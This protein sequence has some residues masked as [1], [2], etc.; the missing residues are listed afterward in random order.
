MLGI[1]EHVPGCGLTLVHAEV[2]VGVDETAGETTEEDTNLKLGHL[3]VSL[4]DA[5]VVAVAIEE[6]QAILL[7][8]GNTSLVEEAVVQSDIFAFGLRGNFDYLKG[9][10]G[11]VVGLGEGHDIGN[12]HS[13]TG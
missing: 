12:E 13:G 7:A 4:D 3:R 8:Q 1:G 5:P 9:L 6:Q 2:V 10:E 11:D